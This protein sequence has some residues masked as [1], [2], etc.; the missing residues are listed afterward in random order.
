MLT[1]KQGA[2]LIRLARQV[3]E[4]NLQLEPTDPVGEEELADPVFQGYKPLFITLNKRGQLRGCIGS[5]IGT[6]SIIDAIKRHA[7]NAAFFD[8]RFSPVTEDEVMELEINISLL[9]EPQ[10]LE[11]QVGDDLEIKLRPGIDGVILRDPTMGAATFLPQV[12]EQLPTVPLFLSHLCGK[13]G[14]PEDTWHKRHLQIQT[15]QVQ[16]FKEH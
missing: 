13:A 16:Y 1:D 8:Q 3:I 14:L 6:E 5:L 11:Y 4:E 10:P 2:I 9:T 12:W 7:V 15:Y